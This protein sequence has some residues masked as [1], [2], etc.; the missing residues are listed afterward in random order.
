MYIKI[1]LAVKNSVDI[2]QIDESIRKMIDET[3][4]D[5]TVALEIKK[6]FNA[7]VSGLSMGKD[8]NGNKIETLVTGVEVYTG[9]D[10]TQLIS[11]WH[12]KG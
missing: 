2:S 10:R 6:E 11:S 8:A 5:S 3:D 7:I 9:E 1:S 12:D 4:G